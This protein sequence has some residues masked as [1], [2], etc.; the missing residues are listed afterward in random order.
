LE[1]ISN[2]ISIETD[3]VPQ[4]DNIQHIL[5]DRKSLTLNNKLRATAK[6]LQRWSDKWIGHIKLQISIALEVILGLDVASDSQSMSHEEFELRKL[7]K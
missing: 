4:F 3:S 7:L 5:V 1:D 6:S 2:L